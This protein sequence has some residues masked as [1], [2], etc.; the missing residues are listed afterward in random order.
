MNTRM[1][2]KGLQFCFTATGGYRHVVD[3]VGV[4]E[5]K[6]RLFWVLKPSGNEKVLPTFPCLCNRTN[7][8]ACMC[9]RSISIRINKLNKNDDSI[10]DGDGMMTT[11]E[12]S[13]YQQPET[14]ART[15]E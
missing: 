5:K 4:C 6:A 12:D 10:A 9:A 7:M 11:K 2:Q 8:Q 13:H 14:A 15:N 1:A 3:R